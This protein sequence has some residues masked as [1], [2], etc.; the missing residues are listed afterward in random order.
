MVISPLFSLFSTPE[1]IFI[2]EGKAGLTP[3][4]QHPSHKIRPRLLR[5]PSSDK[6]SSHSSNTLSSNGT[7]H[8]IYSNRTTGNGSQRV[9]SPNGTRFRSDTYNSPE[10][11]VPSTPSIPALLSSPSSPSRSRSPRDDVRTYR[12]MRKRS[13]PLDEPTPEEPSLDRVPD[14]GGLHEQELNQA[15]IIVSPP[16]PSS[17]VF[18]HPVPGPSEAQL[19]DISTPG[20]PAAR[21]VKCHSK[22]HSLSSACGR[23]S[24]LVGHPII[25]SGNA[26]ELGRQVNGGQANDRQ[27]H[28]LPHLH[29]LQ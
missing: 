18:S 24:S 2:G 23:K 10:S 21:F 6:Y 19:G 17:F 7:A 27:T 4:F 16:T 13:T 15:E 5:Q 26:D 25:P 20:K 3:R 14:L 22:R 8:S 12:E 9:L 28:L 1:P 29:H 11:P